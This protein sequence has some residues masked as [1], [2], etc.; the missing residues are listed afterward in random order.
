MRVNVRSKGSKR[1]LCSEG[2]GGRGGRGGGGRGGR[3]GAGSRKQGRSGEVEILLDE[4]HHGQMLPARTCRALRQNPDIPSAS[5]SSLLLSPVS[6][7][8]LVEG[9]DTGIVCVILPETQLQ[10]AHHASRYWRRPQAA[11]PNAETV[12]GGKAHPPKTKDARSVLRGSFT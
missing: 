5:A 1:L 12:T 4:T 6:A 11:G 3:G 7:P 8:E 10:H 2:Y 9:H